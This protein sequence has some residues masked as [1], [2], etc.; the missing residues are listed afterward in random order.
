VRF[1][2][3][4]KAFR[5]GEE[6]E[7]LDGP[8]LL[9]DG[10]K[11]RRIK[12]AGRITSAL[13]QLRKAA[14]RGRPERVLTGQTQKGFVLL[15][16]WGGKGRYPEGGRKTVFVETRLPASPFTS[17]TGGEP[18]GEKGKCCLTYL[19]AHWKGTNNF[20]SSEKR[21][22]Q[23]NA[24][25]EKKGTGEKTIPEE[26]DILQEGREGASVRHNLRVRPNKSHRRGEKES[27][28]L[29]PTSKE[30]KRGKFA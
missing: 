18:S 27:R 10:L 3:A 9:S 4:R 14:A 2:R 22:R 28:R 5:E 13:P 20:R 15:T 25:G 6:H 7:V 26:N 11:Q 21:I 12:T 16:K 17:Y 19:K 8:A 23:R 30:G 1:P 29:V 24:E